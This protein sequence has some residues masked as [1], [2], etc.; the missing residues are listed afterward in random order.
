M[1]TSFSKDEMD[2]WLDN[3]DATHKKIKDML[4]GKV[5]IDEFDAKEAEEEKMTKLKNDVKLREKQE[6]LLKGRPG[7]GH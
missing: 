2:D 6:V 3:V 1:T 7:K 5:D 4:D